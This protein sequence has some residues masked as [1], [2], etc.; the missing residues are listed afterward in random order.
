VRYE[1]SAPQP[2][3]EPGSMFLVGFGAMMMGKLVKGRH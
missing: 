2:V 1:F 3:P